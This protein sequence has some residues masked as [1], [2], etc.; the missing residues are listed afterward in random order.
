MYRDRTY[1]QRGPFGE[2]FK[3][4]LYLKY[5]VLMVPVTKIESSSY[6]S[7]WSLSFIWVPPSG[8]SNNSPRTDRGL[9]RPPQ[10]LTWTSNVNFHQ[11][12]PLSPSRHLRERAFR[13]TVSGSVGRVRT[14]S[15]R[16][17]G[18]LCQ[19]L[20]R[21][22]DTAGMSCSLDGVSLTTRGGMERG[23]VKDSRNSLRLIKVQVSPRRRP[24]LTTPPDEHTKV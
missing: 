22:G 23:P 8:T 19:R 18:S 10:S 6:N 14:T 16:R 24:H 17:R 4:Y 13:R 7:P 20:P 2:K 5:S 11:H 1:R 3:W 12:P 21:E 9:P 15:G